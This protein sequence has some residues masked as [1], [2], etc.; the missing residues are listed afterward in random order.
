LEEKANANTNP[1]QDKLAI[2]KQQ[3]ALV[4]KKKEKAHNAQQDAER[5]ASRNE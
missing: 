4:S 5:E 1:A 2:Y 3:A